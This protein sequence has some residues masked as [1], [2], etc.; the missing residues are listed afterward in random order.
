MGSEKQI[1]KWIFRSLDVT[2]PCD[3][4]S[5]IQSFGRHTM[6]LREALCDTEPES[7]VENDLGW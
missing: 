1:R 6:I 4:G 2:N 3:P 5:E 7:T